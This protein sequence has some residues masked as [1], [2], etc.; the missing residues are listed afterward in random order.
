MNSS[1]KIFAADIDSQAF[2][3]GLRQL[4]GAVSVVTTGSGDRRAGLTATSVTS[5]SAE[6]P[7]ILVS[8][9]RSASAYATLVN[10]RRFV[11]NVLG[12]HQQ[13]I[14]DR[15]A[16]RD[17]AKGAARFEGAE[18][19]TAA[20][21]A[22]LLVDALAALDCELE[23][24]IERHSHGLLIGRVK[25]LRVAAGAGALLY[26]RGAYE[27]FAGTPGAAEGI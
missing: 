2:R 1:A 3:N 5:F 16:G 24:V 9:A 27:R 4:A 14:A 19:T 22:P 12:D 13:P 7:T 17:G 11:V 15:F 25:A 18:W 21:G 23:E 10:E 20:T 6:P 26:W 8:V